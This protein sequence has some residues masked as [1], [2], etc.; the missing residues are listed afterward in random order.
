MEVWLSGLDVNS[1]QR[2]CCNSGKV[3]E[4]V[5][6]S[7]LVA[8][9]SGEWP[10][11]ALA[12][13]GLHS[14]EPHA[15][16]AGAGDCLLVRGA[17][18]VVRI[19][20][21][22]KDQAKS[23]AR[24]ISFRLLAEAPGLGFNIAHAAFDWDRV[25]GLKQAMAQLIGQ[26]QAQR[27]AP[28]LGGA[29]PPLPVSALCTLTGEAAHGYG[30][31]NNERI[32]P[33]VH[34]QRKWTRKANQRLA[35]II[36]RLNAEPHFEY[37]FEFVTEFG[38]LTRDDTSG[39]H[40][41]LAEGYIAVVC[42]D[43]NGIG[44]LVQQRLGGNGANAE[45]A[46]KFRDF[47]EKIQ[48]ATNAALAD[49]VVQALARPGIEDTLRIERDGHPDD[50]R[51]QLPIRPLVQGG[52]DLTLVCRGDVALDF[53][54]NFLVAFE[55]QTLEHL[56]TGLRAAA[57]LVFIKNGA[58]FLPAYDLAEHLLRSAKKRTR[59]EHCIDFHFVESDSLA[60]LD[61]IR[62]SAYRT[63]DG[64][65]RL[66]RRPYTLADFVILREDAMKL[67]DGLSHGQLNR[68]QDFC[69]M[70]V[71]AS[72]RA[73][74]DIQENISRGLGGRKDCELLATADFEAIFPGGFFDQGEAPSTR[75]ID[76]MELFDF[77]PDRANM[78]AIVH[79]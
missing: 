50:P 51:Y 54:Q 39:Y 17:G 65:V 60:D 68:A 44:E 10:G 15:F 42:I 20:F 14:V 52:D 40:R 67:R 71:A 19:V 9:I 12:A 21:R 37:G 56:G 30:K 11:Q 47:S 74:H 29:M 22:D 57:G 4:I 25:G 16:G 55:A 76:C 23:W 31:D 64:N 58:P 63:A 66:T 3:A 27:N 6:A 18:G 34:H 48:E 7:E 28:T 41:A 73:W 46:A 26:L 78:E 13:V 72:G 35:Y 33:A 53:T 61:A 2:F 45:Q 59:T 38:K 70:G 77:L 36:D 32:S 69:R 49:A 24:A 75:L 43:G 1:I 79:A 62:H 8:Q 5:G